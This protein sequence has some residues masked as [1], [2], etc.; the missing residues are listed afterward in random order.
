MR[1]LVCFC[2]LF[3]S[4]LASAADPLSLMQES[5]RRHRLPSEW[6]RV[7][8]TLREA[9][10]APTSRVLEMFVAQDSKEGD[11]SRIRFLA[12]AE[13]KGT[14]VLTV[15][16]KSG[17]DEQWLYLPAFRKTR[18]LGASELGDRFVDSDVFYEDLRRRRV[19]ENSY[20]LQGEEKVAGQ[21][22]YLIE[23]VPKAA[24][25]IK[26][27]PYGKSQIWLT[28]SSL[29][30]TRIRFFDRS[31]R[32]LKEYEATGLKQVQGDA[33]RADVQTLTDI[34]RKHRTV[35]T[36]T[37]RKVDTAVTADTFSV[38]SLGNE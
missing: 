5:D 17:D 20:T 29:F 6:T 1:V 28:K 26:E 25:A 15:E 33:W 4:G 13:E 14:A 3:L 27:S 2:G 31:L 34:K 22:C 23:S 7:T 9:N 8:M 24:K 12:P 16:S 35:L 38:H 32:P 30:V 36:V 10:G 37:E 19:D 21:D 18:R 11:R